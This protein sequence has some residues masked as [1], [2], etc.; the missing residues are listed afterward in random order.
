MSKTGPGGAPPPPKKPKPPPK[1]GGAPGPGTGVPGPGG[2]KLGEQSTVPIPQQYQALVRKMSAETGMQESIIAAQATV[3]SG[4][5]ANAVSPTGAQ[6][7][8]Q[9]EPGTWS[10]LRCSG[11]P[12][13]I[14]DE[15]TCWIKLMRQLI[16]EFH[17]NVRNVLAAYNAGADDLPAGYGY[18]DEIID[19]AGGGA[20]I[21]PGGVSFSNVTL[22]PLPS[23]GADSW[24]DYINSAREALASA[25][26]KVHA[27]AGSIRAAYQ[28]R[29]D[30][31]NG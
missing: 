9:F 5:N 24:S 25:S 23:V 10:D 6:G 3:E 29:L 8:L 4:F 15:A 30:H 28:E 18:A 26:S 11:S 14:S 2:L 12:F 27:H 17:G 21:T 31:S 19:M 16:A 22:P 13:N 7:W 20:D 1:K